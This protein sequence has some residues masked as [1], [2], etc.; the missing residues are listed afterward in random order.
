M[1][2]QVRIEPGSPAWNKLA[3]MMGRPGDPRSI[4]I[5]PHGNGI[6]MKWGGGTW[7]TP[8]SPLNLDAMPNGR[9]EPCGDPDC[10][11]S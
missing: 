8:L 9:G 7:T 6:Q 5:S 11:C 10:G 1:N 3:E 4:T 2:R